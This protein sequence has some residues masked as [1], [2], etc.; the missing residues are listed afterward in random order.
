MAYAD[1]GNYAMFNRALIAQVYLMIGHS[2]RWYETT[3][4]KISVKAGMIAA[5]A[6]LVMI[7]LAMH[8]WP[9][10]YIDVHLNRYYNL[11][12]TFVMIVLGCAAL[13]ILA[14]RMK[15]VP[16]WLVLIGQNSFLIYMLHSRCFN[17]FNQM[18]D[19]IGLEAIKNVYWLYIPGKIVFAVA[20]C[21]VMAVAFNRFI[22]FLMG[23]RFEL[24]KKL[25]I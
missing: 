19:L 18:L 13:M 14:V 8:I 3:G 24:R 20:A 11:P 9:E 2:F 4:R 23:R 16:R 15:S 12:Y 5:A 25:I 6:W 22:P 10:Q 1:I 21:L 7:M 17:K